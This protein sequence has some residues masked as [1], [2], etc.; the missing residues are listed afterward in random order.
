[1]HHF[2]RGVNSGV[3]LNSGVAH[4]ELFFGRGAL[5]WPLPECSENVCKHQLWRGN[6]Q[7]WRGNRPHGQ[8]FW[9]GPCGAFFFGVGSF[10]VVEYAQLTVLS[11]KMNMWIA[12]FELWR[13]GC[14]V[15]RCCT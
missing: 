3:A 1:M 12:L 14:L 13:G 5:A 4:A 6:G 8:K 7:L 10:G 2:W 15:V 9:R 11:L